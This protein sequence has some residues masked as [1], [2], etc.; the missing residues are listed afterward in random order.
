MSKPK[1]KIPPR[2]RTAGAFGD[3][4]MEDQRRY[5]EDE[6]GGVDPRNLETI[7]QSKDPNADVKPLGR[8]PGAE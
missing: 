3:E 8:L 2:V 4:S 6:C 5:N 7:D 1:T